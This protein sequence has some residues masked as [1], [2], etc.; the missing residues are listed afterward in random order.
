MTKIDENCAKIQEH[1]ANVKRSV[2]QFVET[3]FQVFDAKK[4]EIIN[5][6][7]NQAEESLQR[8]ETNK[9]E[10]EDEVKMSEATLDKAEILLKRS[11][12]AEIMQPN[13]LLNKIFQEEVGEEDLAD[14][15]DRIF[16][17]FNF[18]K[19]S[20]FTRECKR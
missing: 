15:D 1:V 5:E 7:E 18:V 13:K 8:L 9:S 11:A 2:E 16:L 4:Q 10:I 17:E 19:K 3:I 12:S 14:R 20:N 6:V